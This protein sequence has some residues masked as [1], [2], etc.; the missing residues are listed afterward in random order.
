MDAHQHLEVLAYNI[1]AHLL[2]IYDVQN[3]CHLSI[4]YVSKS[5]H[6]KGKFVQAF[7]LRKWKGKLIFY[8]VFFFSYHFVVE[9]KQILL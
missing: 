1:G 2:K 6:I 4:H 5:G 7:F 8:A 9:R 3:K